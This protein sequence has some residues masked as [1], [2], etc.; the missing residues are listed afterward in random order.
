MNAK[1]IAVAP[2]SR[3]KIHRL[4]KSRERR[5]APAL[6]LAVLT[7]VALTVMLLAAKKTTDIL[8]RDPAR[9]V[10]LEKPVANSLVSDAA[11]SMALPP[12][13]SQT[14]VLKGSEGAI[15]GQMARI[16]LENEQITEIKA[17]SDVDNHAGRELLS[18]ISKY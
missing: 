14:I 6:P 13:N 8:R 9:A 2:I 16:P 4:P 1:P 17:V 11:A 3:P 12:R 15:I 18:I 10:R 5:R 7:A